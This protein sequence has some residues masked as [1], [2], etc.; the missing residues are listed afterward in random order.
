M[1]LSE[2]FGPGHKMHGPKRIK[3]LAKFLDMPAREDVQESLKL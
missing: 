1:L 2:R 3:T